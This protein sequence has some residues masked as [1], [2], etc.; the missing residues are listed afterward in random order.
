MEGCRVPLG[1]GWGRRCWSWG[2]PSPMSWPRARPFITCTSG[3]NTTPST[4]WVPGAS[5]AAQAL[6]A[7]QHVPGDVPID[8]EHMLTIFLRASEFAPNDS[9]VFA[10]LGVL[11][12]L[13]R[14]FDK[15]ETAFRRLGRVCF[16]SA[17]FRWAHCAPPARASWTPPTIRCGTSWAPRRPILRTLTAPP[18]PCWRTARPWNSSPTTCV[19]GP[20]WVVACV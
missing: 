3:S 7:R 17:C 4:R 6:T 5:H 15:A 12:N 13:S 11:Y 1:D 19:H 18:R 20:T 8:K 14:E 2:C 9:D 16:C 10:V